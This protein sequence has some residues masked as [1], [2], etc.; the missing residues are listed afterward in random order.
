[1]LRRTINW[2]SC[3]FTWVT[4]RPPFNRARARGAQRS[5]QSGRGDSRSRRQQ[6]RCGATARRR[7]SRSHG[8]GLARLLQGVEN[9]IKVDVRQVLVP[10][11]V[12]E[13]DGHHVTGLTQADF[14]SSRTV[15]K[16]QTDH[17]V[18][19]GKRG[20]DADAPSSDAQ[21]PQSLPH[22]VAAQPAAVRRTYM[23]C[24]DTLHTAFKNFAAVR[25]ALANLFAEE[26]AGDS[27]YV[28]VALG[29]SVEMLVQGNARPR[30]VRGRLFF[31]EAFAETFPRRPTGSAQ[32][33]IW[34]DSGGIVTRNTCT[35][36]S[37]PPAMRKRYV[38]IE[39]ARAADRRYGPRS[40]PRLASC[41][42][43][44]S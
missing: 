19:R 27:Q 32:T 11:V 3:Y 2:G 9:T 10:V 20:R 23:I 34:I 33:P 31:K 25:E 14:R 35:G 8:R 16:G 17:C 1:M 40:Q 38:A 21:L 28:V 29:V 15:W 4:P 39:Y 5:F 44:V 30:L 12:T 26:R 42:D 41:A 7:R 6:G 13:G 18:Q 22:H 36:L 24:I 43:S 37:D